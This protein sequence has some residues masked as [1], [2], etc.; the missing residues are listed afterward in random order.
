M[1]NS[2][3]RGWI[4]AASIGL[5]ALAV[6]P[7]L[8]DTATLTPEILVTAGVAPK[9][10]KE[11][12]SS[13][14]IVTAEDIER[15]QYRTVVDAL[16][17][18]PGLS[19]VQSGGAGTVTSVFARGAN[20]NQTLVLLNGQ[21]ISDPSAPSGAFNFASLLLDNVERIEVVRGPQSALYGSQAIGGVINIVTKTGA[22]T[23]SSTL[24]LEAGTLGTLNTSGSSGG[25]VA[26][27][28]YFVS[29]S[30]QATDGNDIT[31]S[32]YRFGAPEEKDGNENVSSSVQ[33]GGKLNEALRANV[34]LQYDDARADTD[35]DSPG[36]GLASQGRTKQLSLNGSLAGTFAEGRYQPRLTLAYTQYRRHDD[37]LPDSYSVTDS[38]AN[39]EGKRFTVNVDNV[40]RLADWN[41]ASF[42]A[43][44][45]HETFTANGYLSIP[46]P[47]PLYSY[48]SEAQSDASATSYAVYASDHMTFGEG[49]FV[50]VS[51]RYDAPKDFDNQATY[52]VAPGYYLAAT[53][54]KLTLSYGTSFKIPALYERYG[55][56]NTSYGPYVGNPDLK[57]EK[58]TGWDIGLE[59]GILDGALRAGATW[60]QNR[61]KDGVV[62]VYTMSGSTSANADPFRT[63]GVEAFVEATPFATLS[64]RADYTLTLVDAAQISP[65]LRRPRHLVNGTLGWDATDRLNLGTSLQWV[66][67]Y[68]DVRNGPPYGYRK[69]RPY[70]IVNLAGTYKLTESIELTGKINNL[71]D[72]DYEPADGFQAAGIEALAGIAITF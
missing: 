46:D 71:L 65:H 23:P 14:T 9:P 26:G 62:T 6:T 19:V 1:N 64:L 3:L 12:A 67:I 61:I 17:Q 68:D 41:D 59:Q 11:V 44:Y 66:G 52:T 60:F 28:D 21:P 49:F 51:G 70:T 53:D 32:R 4:P 47:D 31:P 27:V 29:L 24:R 8:A 20:S 16:K 22:G 33:L 48:F 43:E 50:T 2:I 58:N 10:T 57:P 25:H 45:R 18:V 30:R 34:F 35:E 54:T 40:V 55:F 7:A 42:G 37:N 72:R 63:K 56:T 13:Y 69:S 39:N 38:L 15:F 36:A 5:S